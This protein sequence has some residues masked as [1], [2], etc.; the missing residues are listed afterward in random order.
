MKTFRWLAATYVGVVLL[1]GVPSAQAKQVSSEI[2]VGTASFPPFRI[3]E[4][5]TGSG[6]GEPKITGADTEIVEA[7]FGRMGKKIALK[8]A[9][10]KRI[11]AE[12]E[13]GKYAAVFAFTANPEREKAY[14]LSQPINMVRDVL[15]KRSA[16]PF[17]WKKFDDLA[18]KTIGVSDGYSYFNGFMDY[19][20]SAKSPVD[21][22][23]G[24]NPE[25]EQLRKLAKN[26]TDVFICEVNVCSWLLR[27]NPRE[28]SS[29]TFID[30]TIGPARPWHVGF[31]KK[32][33]G[34]KKLRDE[35]DKALTAYIASGERDLVFKKYGIV[36][37]D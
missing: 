27:Q 14:Y 36:R 33:P 37:L 5:E 6:S 8:T 9:P 15:F 18:G 4:N 17:T 26:R 3:I 16:D 32:N 2:L 20:K 24:T 1:T 10:W 35:F 25:T 7:V 22:S 30:R 19:L 21:R 34:G 29:L 31:S 12:G 23:F 28:L 11:Y 13:A